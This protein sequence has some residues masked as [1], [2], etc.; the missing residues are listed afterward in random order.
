MNVLD[1]IDEEATS[2]AIGFTDDVLSNATPE[3]RKQFEQSLRAA[4]LAG[5]TFA[6]KGARQMVREVRSEL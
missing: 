1:K 3:F 6:V 5:A 2:Y 4:F